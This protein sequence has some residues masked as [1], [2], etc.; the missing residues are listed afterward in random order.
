MHES[1]SIIYRMYKSILDNLDLCHI[2]HNCVRC[3]VKGQEAMS[4][5]SGKCL[6]DMWHSIWFA[7]SPLCLFCSLLLQMFRMP[8]E[9][10]WLNTSQFTI[11]ASLSMGL[12]E[13]KA[14][15]QYSFLRQ[16]N[17]YKLN[18]DPELLRTESRL[19]LASELPLSLWG[20]PATFLS[21]RG[22]RDDS[23]QISDGNIPLPAQPCPPNK[24]HLLF[25]F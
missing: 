22:K 6:A 10:K 20:A 15:D 4:L 11:V 21:S 13:G 23:C 24:L 1:V 5:W 7:T 2:Y 25:V 9:V 19:L 18:T 14:S 8:W 3:T 17:S 16:G 12:W